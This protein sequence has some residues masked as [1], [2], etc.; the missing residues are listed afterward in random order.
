[1]NEFIVSE[2]RRKKEEQT[3]PHGRAERMRELP[4]PLPRSEKKSMGSKLNSAE[5][6]GRASNGATKTGLFGVAPECKTPGGRH[7]RIKC[8][9]LGDLLSL[10]ASPF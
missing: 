5:T 8:L 3:L 7:R 2:T 6:V 10:T 1:M 4:C 9:L